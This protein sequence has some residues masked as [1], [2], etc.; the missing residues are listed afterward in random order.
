M[1]HILS[2]LDKADRWLTSR[3]LVTRPRVRLEDLQVLDRFLRRVM[4]ACIALGLTLL[5]ALGFYYAFIYYGTKSPFTDPRH[6]VEVF[7]PAPTLGPRVI[8]DPWVD[9]SY[10]WASIEEAQALRRQ[11]QVINLA[12][13][14]TGNVRYSRDKSV[15]FNG[16][17]EP[18]QRSNPFGLQTL[19]VEGTAVQF[20]L[21]GFTYNLNVLQPFMVRSEPGTIYVVD[22]KGQVW[23]APDTVGIVPLDQVKTQPI[24]VNPELSLSY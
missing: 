14:S 4:I 17:K 2:L 1:N 15:S 9:P 24:G 18:W 5:V 22:P 8:N 20:S 11:A 23:K 3:R 19:S 13:L 21:S 16:G 12:I 6:Q 7:Q 10:N